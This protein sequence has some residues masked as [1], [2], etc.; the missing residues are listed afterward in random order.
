MSL[1]PTVEQAIRRL[2]LDDDL[3][4]D[5]RDAI[6]AAFAETLAF[7]DGRL[8]EVESPESL[9]D[10]RAIIMTP[11]IIAAQLLLAD[12]LVG[13]NDTRAREYKRTAAFNIL[14]PR[15]IAGC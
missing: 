10:P 3:T 11:D 6:E 15:R 7:L 4:G 2:R 12:A 14:R 13:A 1:K 9:L 8:Y 5:V